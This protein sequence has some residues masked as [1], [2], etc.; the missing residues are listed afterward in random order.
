M[1]ENII[2]NEPIKDT[3]EQAIKN[4]KVSHSYLYLGT[5]GIGKKMMAIEFAKSVL[6]LDEKKHCNRCKSCVE[7]DSNNN[8]DFLLI[9]PDGTSIKIEQIRELQKK[10]QEKP[11]ISNNKIYII[12]DADLMIKRS[13][14]LFIKDIRRTT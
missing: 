3:L 13:T 1:F 4:N 12:N 6:C 7:F 8:P 2:G 5:S 14:E 11:I 9:E 10:I